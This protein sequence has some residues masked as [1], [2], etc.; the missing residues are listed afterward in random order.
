MG[1]PAVLALVTRCGR[2]LIE[3][4]TQ[5]WNHSFSVSKPSHRSAFF[6]LRKQNAFGIVNCTYFSS[7]A[8]F[9]I[10][11]RWNLCDL[12][13]LMISSACWVSTK[14]VYCQTSFRETHF[15][16]PKAL[17]TST[18]RQRSL[19]TTKNAT[20]RGSNHVLNG[21]TIETSTTLH[22]AIDLCAW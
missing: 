20:Q 4:R 21:L 19:Q 10:C 9:I 13:Q 14:A 3:H 7:Y 8:P 1:P 11:E 16:C 2:I 15:K 5:D 17:I 12:S 22:A 18:V 6:C